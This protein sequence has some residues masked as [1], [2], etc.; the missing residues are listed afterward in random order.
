MYVASDNLS[1]GRGK[2]LLDLCLTF[3]GFDLALGG[4][5]GT[6][7]ESSGRRRDPSKARSARSMSIESERLSGRKGLEQSTRWAHFRTTK[8]RLF[9]RRNE[10][11]KGWNRR[12]HGL[13]KYRRRFRE[14]G[15]GSGAEVGEVGNWIKLSGMVH[16]T[17]EDVTE[18]YPDTN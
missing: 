15:S 16:A 5:G 4:E 3:W 9:R 10:R 8:G 11:M 18:T 7:R 2:R 13:R 14:V 6:D 1:A 12:R 17:D